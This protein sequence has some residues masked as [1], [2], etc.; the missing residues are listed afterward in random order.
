MDSNVLQEDTDMRKRFVVVALL[1][2]GLIFII[3]TKFNG[4]VVQTN[5]VSLD[6]L[7]IYLDDSWD[8]ENAASLPLI[9]TDLIRYV[10]G[11]SISKKVAQNGSGKE[12]TIQMEHFFLPSNTFSEYME[13][14]VIIP[15]DEETLYE[16]FNIDG[17]E[18]I[19]M[20]HKAEQFTQRTV[21]VG[22]DN[23]FYSITFHTKSENYDIY[24]DEIEAIIDTI[25]IKSLK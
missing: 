15:D 18:A 11:K 23:Y 14:Y 7:S 20:L 24:I 22:K 9:G 6:G 17:Y 5:N 19:K 4:S 12:I 1:L 21:A 13:N 3:F 8:Y 10:G 25:K 2:L 16:A